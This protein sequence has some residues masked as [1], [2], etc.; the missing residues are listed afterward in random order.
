VLSYGDCFCLAAGLLSVRRIDLPLFVANTGCWAKE[1][2]L[3]N[4][5]LR[6]Q[7]SKMRSPVKSLYSVT[8]SIGMDDITGHVILDKKDNSIYI[9]YDDEIFGNTQKPILVK[10]SNTKIPEDGGLDLAKQICHW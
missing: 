4:L 1:A 7:I 5:L 9:H 8:G 10:H 2:H 3:L 6:L